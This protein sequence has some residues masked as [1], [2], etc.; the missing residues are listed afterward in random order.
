MIRSA[1][2]LHIIFFIEHFV[3][4]ESAN[5]RST[6]L[7]KPNPY[8]QVII[9]DNISRKTEVIKNTLHP[10]WK[11]EFTVLVTPLSKITFRL[12]DHHSFR[13]DNILGEKRVNFLK[14]LLYFNGKIENVEMT[15][16]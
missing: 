11:E 13:K 4:V 1:L 7:F 12:A 3:S 6:G 8:L 15:I 9:D 10:K 2:H 5:I 16:G 14:V